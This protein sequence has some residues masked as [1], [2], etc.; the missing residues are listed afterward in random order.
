MS[1]EQSLKFVEQLQGWA[2][3]YYPAMTNAKELPDG[4]I[5]GFLVN[6]S[7]AVLAHT[8]AL[9]G[10]DGVSVPADLVRLFPG[11]AEEEFREHGAGCFGVRPGEPR[12]CVEFATIA[13]AP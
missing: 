12:Y 6:R 4:I 9:K 1:P 13:K 8:A 11:H 5:L 3:T 10:A 2:R 7:G